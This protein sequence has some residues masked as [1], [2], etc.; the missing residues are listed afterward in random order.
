MKKKDKKWSTEKVTD[1]VNALKINLERLMEKDS[2]VS[3]IEKL[4]SSVSR[5]E[6]AEKEVA[7]LKEKLRS[8][9]VFLNEER[10]FNLEL[11]KAAKKLLKNKPAKKEKSEKK[12]KKEKKKN[13]EKVEE[14]VTID[15]IEKVDIVDD[16][17]ETTK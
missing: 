12:E 1:V 7:G 17:L 14:K 11:A 9:K 3:I 15:E 8:K 10:E 16:T 5:I 13:V 2:D 4:E 6:E